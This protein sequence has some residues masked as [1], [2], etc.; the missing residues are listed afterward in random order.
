MKA[1]FLYAASMVTAI[2]ALLVASGIESTGNGWAMLGYAFGSLCLLVLAL[3]LAALGCCA[4]RPK[5]RR[6]HRAPADTVKP[7][8][9]RKAG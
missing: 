6:V 3:V 9:R 7:K 2:G 8:N 1:T 4:E 5:K